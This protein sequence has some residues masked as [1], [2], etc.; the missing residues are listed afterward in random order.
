MQRSEINKINT[1]VKPGINITQS[2]TA[3]EP[4]NKSE[5]AAVD[6]ELNFDTIDQPVRT[7]EAETTQCCAYCTG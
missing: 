2:Q 5:T 6:N 1:T 7:I 3:N 4:E